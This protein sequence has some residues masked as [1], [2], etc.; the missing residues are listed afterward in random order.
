MWKVCRSSLVQHKFRTRFPSLPHYLIFTLGMAFCPQAPGG[1]TT[2]VH[3]DAAFNF[4]V[5]P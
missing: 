2:A 3:I 4:A 1:N 5:G